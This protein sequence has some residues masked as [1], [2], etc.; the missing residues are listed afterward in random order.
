VV[1]GIALTGITIN[2]TS[3]LETGDTEGAIG[4]SGEVDLNTS[5]TTNTSEGFYSNALEATTGTL[6]NVLGYQYTFVAGD[7]TVTASA[8]T[9]PTPEV[10]TPTPTTPEVETPTPT[11]PEVEVPNTFLQESQNTNSLQPIKTAV[12]SLASTENN[13]TIKAVLTDE[14]VVSNITFVSN[15]VEKELPEASINDKNDTP[16]QQADTSSNTNSVFDLTKPENKVTSNIPSLP[17][18]ESSPSLKV[19]VKNPPLLAKN[20]LLSTDAKEF[21]QTQIEN[22]SNSLSVASVKQPI[23]VTKPSSINRMKTTEHWYD[24]GLLSLLMY[25]GML[26]GSAVTFLRLCIILFKRK[27]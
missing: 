15:I 23:T 12:Y 5:Y 24:D 18:A 21:K 13:I 7:L 8:P 20:E 17:K 2:Y 26:L 9:P 3:G 4:S 1:A 22:N 27:E 11:T 10:E 19:D 16:V 6:S 25:A 14:K